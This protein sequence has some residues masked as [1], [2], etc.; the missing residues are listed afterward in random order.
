MASG[1]YSGAWWVIPTKLSPLGQ[2][3]TRS[4]A[5]LEEESEPIRP[6]GF[7]RSEERHCTESVSQSPT[8]SRKREACAYGSLD[9]FGLADYRDEL[10]R[11]L[12]AIQAAQ[13]SR[14]TPSAFA[15]AA[16]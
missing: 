15:R 8:E 16:H 10:D 4:E 2:R 14:A 7:A 5:E 9:R 12:A 13:R 3:R 1:A 6:H 11:K